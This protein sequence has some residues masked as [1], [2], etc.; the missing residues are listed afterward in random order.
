MRQS[1]LHSF[2]GTAIVYQVHAA[3]RA[4]A[5]WL[6]ICNGY[7]GTFCA[8]EQVLPQ[9]ADACHVLVWDYRGQHLSG[10]PTDKR[11]LR[12]EDS[13]RDAERLMEAEGVERFVVVGWSVGV[14]VAL[15]LWRRN[16]HRVDAVGLIHGAHDRILRRLGGRLSSRVINRPL[17]RVMQRLVPLGWPVARAPARKMA[18]SAALMPIMRAAGMVTG[19]PPAFARAVQAWLEMDMP[20]YVRMARMADDHETESW[21]H[22]V[23]VPVLITAGGKDA[24]TPPSIARRAA[25]RIHDCEYVEFPDGTHYTVMEYPDE[26]AGHLRRLLERA[27]T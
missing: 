10:V 14:Q 22:S 19:E 11:N 3:E 25:A 15:E 5:P 4:D 8:W 17:G 9:L 20:T 21:L 2:D 27:A 13:C 26:M 6:V 1:T 24:I 12:I 16:R 7:G 18:R 23:D